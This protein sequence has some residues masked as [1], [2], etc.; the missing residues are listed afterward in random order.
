MGLK[1]ERFFSKEYAA[2]MVKASTLPFR[3]ECLR[4]GASYVFTEEL[5]DKKVIGSYAR[6]CSDGT[7]LFLTK[8]DEARTVH[9]HPGRR[10][11]T[12]AQLGTADGVLALQASQSLLDYVSE[13]NINMGCPKSFSMSGGMGAALLSNPDQAVSIV[14]TLKSELPPE[15]PVS[16]KI[17]YIGDKCDEEKML[18]RTSEF[19]LGLSRAGA[20]AITVHMRTTPMRPREPAM[21][22][23]FV[24][25]MKILPSEMR[26]VPVI[27]NGDF[28]DR[29]Q[30]SVFR[31]SVKE[32]LQDV[33]CHGW[34]DS[35]MIA[36]GA[37]WN[38]S[39]FSSSGATSPVHVVEN[40]LDRCEE[41]KEP[42]V[43]VKWILAQM[44]DGHSEIGGMSVKKM[45]EKVHASHSLEELREQL[46][47]SPNPPKKNRYTSH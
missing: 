38:P 13:I 16:C 29:S 24:G 30:V 6:E 34:S 45:R 46:E 32:G 4:Y 19:M 2:P 14:K 25:L 7:V 31:E 42:F 43:S 1:K 36:R 35:V 20:D 23:G 37:M 5:I 27:A 17:R 33:A 11:E 44:M 41:L 3:E 28:F 8:K 15:I 40:F 39:V 10:N 21:W 12:I 22:A 9:F 26:D 47:F 18:S